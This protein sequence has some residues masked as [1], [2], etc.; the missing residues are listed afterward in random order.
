[1]IATAIDGFIMLVST[2]ASFVAKAA[3]KT[4]V[5]K[6]L[7]KRTKESQKFIRFLI[8]LLLKPGIVGAIIAGIGLMFRWEKC[9]I[10]SLISDVMQNIL[11][12]ETKL[13]GKVYEIYSAISSVGSFIAFCLDIFD[14]EPN[15]YFRI[16][17]A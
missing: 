13:L 17:F 10:D 7:L 6:F 2:V 14:G 8:D 11:N 3:I 9:K 12:A 16:K 5:R 15:G 1:M 4:V